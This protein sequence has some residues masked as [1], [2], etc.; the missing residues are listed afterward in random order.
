MEGSSLRQ[1][2][3]VVE[4]GVGDP[5]DATELSLDAAQPGLDARASRPDFDE[6]R[7]QDVETAAPFVALLQAEEYRVDVHRAEGGR[8]YRGMKVS[9]GETR[10]GAAAA[11]HR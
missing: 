7:L 1:V 4:Q 3:R 10:P 8:D 9:A 5:G 6:G 11:G 2:R